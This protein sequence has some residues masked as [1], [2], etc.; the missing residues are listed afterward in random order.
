MGRWEPDAR[1]RLS[2]AALELYVERGFERTTVAEIAERAGLTERTFFRHFVDKREVL[3]YGAA[4]LQD[5]VVAAVAGAP[6]SATP[7]EAVAAGLE[8]AGGMIRENPERARLRRAVI[9]ANVELQERELAKMAT[10]S[11]AMA[12]A[13]RSR[14]VE[15]LAAGL[16]AEAGI[17]AFKV[18]FGRW[19]EGGCE[20]D[21]PGLLRGTL[22]SLG[23]VLGR[24]PS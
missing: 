24:P 23:A 10:L 3:F 18:G 9:A 22:S 15:D 21:L 17:A 7:V 6:E 14:G 16:I 11:T 1:G 13:L 19:V 12:G 8:A 4:L 2:R 20:A 5:L